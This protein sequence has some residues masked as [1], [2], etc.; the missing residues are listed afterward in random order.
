MMN[1][2][3][4]VKICKFCD[5]HIDLSDNTY[6]VQYNGKKVPCQELANK[7]CDNLRIMQPRDGRSPADCVNPCRGLTD[8]TGWEEEAKKIGM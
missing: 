1:T 3:M 7:I 4:T 8:G 5:A 2:K 6:I